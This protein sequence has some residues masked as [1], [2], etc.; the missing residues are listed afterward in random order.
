MK[1][2]PPPWYYDD[3]TRTIRS[4]EGDQWLATIAHWNKAR[5]NHATGQLIVKA[6][7]RHAGMIKCLQDV[8]KYSNDPGVIK[9]VRTELSKH[10]V[11]K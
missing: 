10:G 1:A 2:I 9:F 7:N 4:R 5:C 6:V 11:E 8:V 3:K